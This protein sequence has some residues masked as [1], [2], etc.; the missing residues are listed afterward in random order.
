MYSIAPHKIADETNSVPGDVRSFTG[1]IKI[2]NAPNPYMGTQGPKVIP[3][4]TIY[5]KSIQ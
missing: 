3:L 2:A 5:P 4:L 1:H